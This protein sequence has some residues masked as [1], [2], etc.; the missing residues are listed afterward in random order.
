MSAVFQ[1]GLPNGW[2]VAAL[3]EVCDIIL[4]Q[5][6]PGTTYNSDGR[7]L[8][9]FQGKADFGEL[10]PVPSKWCT[11]PKKLARRDDVLISVRA[12]VG[13]T[14]LCPSEA[15]IGRGLAALR[16]KAGMPARYVLYALRATQGDLEARAT[17]STFSAVDGKTLRAH[18]IP[19]A[20]EGLLGRIVEEIE[21]QLTR[22]DAGVAALKCVQANL[23]RYRAAVLKA[24]CEGRLVPTEAELARQEGHTYEPASALLARIAAEQE[25]AGK[26]AG[27]PRRG[28]PQRA[29]VSPVSANLPLLPK[30]WCWAS[31]VEL[32]F[33]RENAICAGPFGTIFKARDFR[34]AGVPIIFLRHIEPGRYLTSKPGFMDE[35]KWQEL[36]RPYSVYGG[37]LLITKLGDPP[38]VSAQYPR[39][40]GPAMVTPDVIKMEVNPGVAVPLYVMNYLNSEVA[41]RLST[42]LAF[43]TTRQRLTIPI[44]RTLPV[45]LPPLAEQHRIVAEVERRLSLAHDLERVVSANLQ[46]ATRLRQSILAAAFCAGVVSQARDARLH[47]LPVA[48]GDF[49][50]PPAKS[51][52]E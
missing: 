9:F 48:P 3:Q 33:D 36:F 32:A 50:A 35:K 44:F 47:A 41:R 51:K 37:E 13:P 28:R 26:V 12:P 45:A 23:K 6:P 20:P 2:R 40:I 22:L 18:A 17:G 4:G 1:A 42:T 52:G 10:Y 46:R 7:G 34:P 49:P 30:G 43:G 29:G 8:P 5:S 39:G 11:A 31:P 15:C 14:N 19:L 24:A 25:K 16:P 21:K 38:G 27:P